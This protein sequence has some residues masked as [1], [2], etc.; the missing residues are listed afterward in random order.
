MQGSG[1]QHLKGCV[2][3]WRARAQEHEKSVTG[4][5]RGS[6]GCPEITG[7]DIGASAAIRTMT[8]NMS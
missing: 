1:I 5:M 2:S 8:I 6:C 7:E 4:H 3:L